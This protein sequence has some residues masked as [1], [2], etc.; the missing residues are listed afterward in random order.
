MGKL[1]VALWSCGGS[2]DD[3]EEAFSL[4]N[5][6]SLKIFDGFRSNLSSKYITAS[7]LFKKTGWK[8]MAK[9]IERADI[10]SE[11][12]KHLSKFE[13]NTGEKPEVSL[14]VQGTTT[15]AGWSIAQGGFGVIANATDQG[16][17]GKGI[18]LTSSLQYAHLY[19]T[20]KA[21]FQSKL[22]GFLVCV[23]VPGN[24][25][26]MVERENGRSVEDSYQSHYTIGSRCFL[27]NLLTPQYSYF[28][29]SFS[30]LL[31][32]Y[33]VDITKYPNSYPLL[34]CKGNPNGVDEL[35]CFQESQ[36]LP[37]F[38]VTL[39]SNPTFAPVTETP[40]FNLQP[41]SP[42]PFSTANTSIDTR[43]AF[44]KLKTQLLIDYLISQGLISTRMKF[45]SSRSRR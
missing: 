26:P 39:K 42:P 28:F 8:L 2:L 41:Q 31:F 34:P 45:P 4:F 37:L 9:A 5:S 25:F 33:L 11:S 29:S 1:M 13:W 38:L 19:A 3:V 24:G 20:D 44:E 27:L 18:Y 10:I 30:F 15:E 14:M 43:G 7:S 23:V 40:L 35:V 12:E 36:V 16:W 17:Y 6:N 21:R 22:P 32:I